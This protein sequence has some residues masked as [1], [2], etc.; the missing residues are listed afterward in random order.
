LRE[1]LTEQRKRLVSFFQENYDR[2]LTVEEIEQTIDGISVSAI[3]RN[4]NHLVSE[5]AVRRFQQEG[6]RKF[7]Y[8]YIGNGDCISHLHLKCDKCG[9]I[10]HM[11]T[12]AVEAIVKLVNENSNF[13]LDR[14]KTVLFGLCASCK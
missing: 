3:Y 2:Q 1:Y 10:F 13:Y 12:K 8:Q 5:G 9:N 4:I 7:F 6:S 11:D 14:S